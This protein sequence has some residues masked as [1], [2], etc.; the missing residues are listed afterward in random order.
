MSITSRHIE[1]MDETE[2]NSVRSDINILLH[3]N[4]DLYLEQNVKLRLMMIL[5]LL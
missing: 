1:E 5:A 4:H 3:P 2:K